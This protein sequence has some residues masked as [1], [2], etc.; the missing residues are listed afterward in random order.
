MLVN[1]ILGPYDISQLLQKVARR[2]LL[3]IHVTEIWPLLRWLR[4]YPGEA[5][6]QQ[7]FSWSLSREAVREKGKD[8][9]G[10]RERERKKGGACPGPSREILCS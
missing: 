7:E 2:T 9:E 4:L 1:A 5:K 8:G 3:K 6:E 10:H